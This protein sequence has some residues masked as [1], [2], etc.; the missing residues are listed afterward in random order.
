MKKLPVFI[1][2]LIVVGIV[3]WFAFLLSRVNI[4]LLNPRGMIASS[5]R[6]LIVI[7]MTLMFSIAIPVVITA[8]FIIW[9]YRDGG[10]GKHSPEK[11]G[12]RFTLLI[13]WLFFSELVVVFFYIIIRSSFALDPKKEIPSENH[14]KS[15]QVV[16]LNWKWLFIYPEENIATVNFLQIPVKTPIGF[17][18][19]ADGPM[20]SFW[21]PQLGGQIY[22]MAAM[23]THINLIADRTGDFQGSAAEINGEG[24]AGMRFITRSSTDEDFDSWVKWVKE[25][26]SPLT[27]KVYEELAKPSEDSPVIY[28]SEVDPDLYNN[29]MV[30]YMAPNN[31]GEMKTHGH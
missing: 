15:V 24:F 23:E 14:T 20:N 4:Q 6:D 21:I 31:S 27:A 17:K 11:T 22:S 1:L 18:L 26:G 30:K 9:K 19:T 7:A 10:G 13:Y 2:V 5:Q 8:F 16:A 29:I 25:N 3:S 12:G 28:Y